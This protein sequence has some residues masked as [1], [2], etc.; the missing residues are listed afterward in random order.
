MSTD[1]ACYGTFILLS[2]FR[3]Q[4]LARGAGR[5]VMQSSPEGVRVFIFDQEYTMRGQLDAEYIRKLARYLDEKMRSIAARTNNVDSL[6]TAVLA[7]LNIADEY[8]QLLSLHESEMIAR[9]AQMD[10]CARL[11]DEVLGDESPQA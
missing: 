6:R 3:F 1:A 7:A 9:N 11:L 5:R 10:Q 8:H 4:R 2:R